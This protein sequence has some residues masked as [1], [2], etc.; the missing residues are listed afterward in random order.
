MLSPVLRPTSKALASPQHNRNGGEMD[1][2]PRLN[3]QQAQLVGKLVHGEYK[4]TEVEQATLEELKKMFP[5]DDPPML[6]E[7]M[8]N[9]LN[10]SQCPFCKGQLELVDCGDVA[11]DVWVDMTC[12]CTAAERAGLII[13]F[14]LTK[15]SIPEI[16]V[17]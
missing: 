5:L 4:G 3:Q 7:V 1:N 12:N 15:F 10:G 8:D 13:R 11:G 6:A 9:L 16:S 17:K 14:I 2:R